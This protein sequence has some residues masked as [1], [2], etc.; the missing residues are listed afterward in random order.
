MLD[1]VWNFVAPGGQE[2]IEGL[3]RFIRNP[4]GAN[5]AEEARKKIRTW[6]LGRKRAVM[7]QI[8]E[9]S[10]IEQMRALEK[11]IKEVEKK[12]LDFSHRVTQMKFSREGRRPTSEWV[13]EFQR[14]IEEELAM[15][16]ADELVLKTGRERD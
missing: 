11:L 3:T 10:P 8:P 4:G 5:T 12:H 14:L 1:E 7:M 6:I 2:E 16:E 15:V 13:T 9:L